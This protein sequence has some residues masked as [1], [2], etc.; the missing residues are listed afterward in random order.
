MERE[1]KQVEDILEMLG[2][3]SIPSIIRYSYPINEK[4]ERAK[5]FSVRNYIP[6]FVYSKPNEE[7]LI[8]KL[9]LLNKIK[10]KLREKDVNI[11]VKMLV[12]GMLKRKENEILFLLNLGSKNNIIVAKDI[13][14]PPTYETYKIAIN[15]V[16]H[17]GDE[18]KE[19]RI[20][21][22][23]AANYFSEVLNNY[24][25][26]WKVVIDDNRIAVSVDSN[27]KKLYLPLH[28]DYSFYEL[29]RLSVH[30]IGTHIFRKENADKQR[31]I[32]FRKTF[33]NYL[34][35]EEGMA[36]YH[37][38]KY[39]LLDKQRLKEYALRYIATYLTYNGRPFSYTF[40]SLYDL[41]VNRDDAWRITLRA[42]RGGGLIKDY[43][44]LE[45]FLRVKRFVELHGKRG[46][47]IIMCC[48]NSIDYYSFMKDAMA[49]GI[50]SL[51]KYNDFDL[52]LLSHTSFD[53]QYD[54]L[55]GVI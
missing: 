53:E 49:M 19:G 11:D 21:A 1:I 55:V 8:N 30:E 40:N 48:R 3:I 14:G 36:I 22:K 38:Y 35:T 15:M 31:I 29:Q 6:R 44:Y 47:E 28:R 46:E 20:K 52:S 16:E 39:N 43:V 17:I 34:I 45:G 13:D 27:G 50:V 23:D 37:E 33:P 4:E 9:K 5:F 2:N 26:M 25:L 51:P 41:G 54:N 10:K 24:G 42:W 7:R 18:S 32:L 12:E